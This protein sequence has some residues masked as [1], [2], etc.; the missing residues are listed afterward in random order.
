MS[1]EKIFLLLFL[2]AVSN[3]A[4]WLQCPWEIYRQHLPWYRQTTPRMEAIDELMKAKTIIMIAHRT[5]T[6]QNADQILVVDEGKVV[7]R[8]KHEQL[9]KEEGIY[10]RFVCQREKTVS[11][12]L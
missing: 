10:R 12:K 2:P 6:V 9:K 7:Q 4:P 8:G 11:W 1:R 5:K 3:S